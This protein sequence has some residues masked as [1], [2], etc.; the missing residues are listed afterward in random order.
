MEVP[1]LEVP[2]ELQLPAY[3]TATAVWDLSRIYDICCSLWHEARDGTRIFMDT[4]LGS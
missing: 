3:T 2:S 1:R 4:L